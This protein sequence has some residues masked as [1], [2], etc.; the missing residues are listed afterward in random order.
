MKKYENSTISMS[1]KLQFDILWR[2]PI[3][4][5]WYYILFFNISFK[6]EPNVYRHENK[7]LQRMP[8]YR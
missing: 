3:N 4:S 6:T 1:A 8:V 2:V 7:Q 5:I